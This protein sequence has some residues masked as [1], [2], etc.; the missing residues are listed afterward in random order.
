MQKI[1]DYFYGAQH[2]NLGRADLN[3]YSLIV[4]FTDIQIRKVGEELVAPSSALPLGTD[5]K[6]DET[7][8]IKIEPG[9]IL[10]HSILAVSNAV[11]D[12]TEMESDLLLH[13]SVAGFIYMYFLESFIMVILVDQQ[14]M[15]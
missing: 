6:A 11:C 14:L 9:N 5:R 8:M 10:M 2:T 4:P 7:K 13:S 3:P 15:K 12:D 1:R